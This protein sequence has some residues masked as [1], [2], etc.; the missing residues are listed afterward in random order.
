MALTWDEIGELTSLEFEAQARYDGDPCWRTVGVMHEWAAAD[1]AAL[2]APADA[3][4]R[5][6]TDRRVVVVDRPPHCYS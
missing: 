6:P 3:R 4:G 2:T 5:P 1:A